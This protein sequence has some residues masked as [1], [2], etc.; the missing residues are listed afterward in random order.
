MARGV[1]KLFGLIG[2][3]P[4]VVGEAGILGPFAAEAVVFLEGGFVFAGLVVLERG[5]GGG[6]GGD[7]AE[8]RKEKIKERGCCCGRG[9]GR[10]RSRFFLSGRNISVMSKT[11]A[12]ASGQ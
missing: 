9:R 7:R 2:C 1:L 12:I 5:G 4:G 8:D 6:A 11:I 10:P 3:G